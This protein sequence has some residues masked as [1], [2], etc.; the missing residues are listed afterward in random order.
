MDRTLP[1]LF[2]I[3]SYC[4]LS[5]G[6]VVLLKEE[7]APAQDAKAEEIK[8]P[9]ILIDG[10]KPVPPIQHQHQNQ[11]AEIPQTAM[12]EVIAVQG[13][14]IHAR[15][16]RSVAPGQAVLIYR[17]THYADKVYSYQPDTLF[18]YYRNTMRPLVVATPARWH[19]RIPVA[20]AKLIK[21]YDQWAQLKTTNLPS[22]H[23]KVG[24]QLIAMVT[25]RL[26]S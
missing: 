18:D 17:L 25:P 10:N 22:T 13:Q 2:L 16:D 7:G 24:D 9:S 3:I 8:E 19:A 4:L 11:T 14:W 6:C 21:Q 26:G 12:G 23:V 20:H 5:T 1:F 15:F